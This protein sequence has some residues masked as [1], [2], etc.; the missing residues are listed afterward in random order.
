MPRCVYCGTELGGVQKICDQC[1]EERYS[2]VSSGAG[3][4]TFPEE[5]MLWTRLAPI[6]CCLIA[7]NALVFLLVIAS[8]PLVSV[9]P[10]CFL[11]H[12]NLLHPTVQ[13]LVL[14]GGDYAPLTVSGQWWRLLTSAFLHSGPAHLFF[15]M[16]ALLC[17]G[18]LVER[19]F[20]KNVLLTVYLLASVMSSL[21]SDVWHPT[22]V[23]VGASG[24]IF[25]LLGFLM[26]L[27]LFR[28][29]SIQLRGKRI[30]PIGILLGCVAYNLV[31]GAIARDVD[32]AGHLGGFALGLALGTIAVYMVRPRVLEFVAPGVVHCSI[33]EL[34]AR[35]TSEN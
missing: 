3:K 23:A 16:Y 30:F 18:C 15:N 21:A 19:G 11:R 22:D 14:W 33:P 27:V 9:S 5:L 4:V 2:E 28:R 20:G 17:V 6:T 7:I 1:W 8:G 10:N 13:Q 26:P 35:A 25:G 32:N 34:A 29:L 12:S 24:A 31:V